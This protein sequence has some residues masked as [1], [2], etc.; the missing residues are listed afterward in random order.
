[1]GLAVTAREMVDAARALNNAETLDESNSFVTDA[2]LLVVLNGEL[3][4]LMDVILENADES[5]TRGVHPITLEPGSSVYPL[6]PGNYLVTSVDI[7]WSAGIRRSAHRFTESERNRFRGIQPSWSHFGRVYF[8]TVGQNIEFIPAPQTA[9]TALVNYEPAFT[10]ITDIENDTFDSQ[11]GWH[12][13]AV[14]GLGAYIATK[15]DNAAKTA[16]CLTQKERQL[17][18]VR[19][20]AGRRIEGEP[21]RVQR[22]RRGWED[23]EC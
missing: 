23:D 14:F 13:A 18:R 17:E 19:S 9:V 16:Y 2:E 21:P 20:M 4:E 22:T 7:E 5:Y 11:N 6:P 10:P 8:R 1:M 3:A 12:L 15:D